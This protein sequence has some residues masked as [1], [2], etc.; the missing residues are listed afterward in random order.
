[1][2]WLALLA[3][4]GIILVAAIDSSGTGNWLGYV[5]AGALGALVL[6]N[7]TRARMRSR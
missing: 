3:L 2:R 1:L 6:T 4:A 5:A 7:A